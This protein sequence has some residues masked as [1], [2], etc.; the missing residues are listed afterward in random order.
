MKFHDRGKQLCNG[1]C[2]IIRFLELFGSARADM[3]RK[4]ASVRI[5][6][7]I[8]NNYMAIY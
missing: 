8:I 2:Y 4:R 5:P 7:S 6:F 3:K 1:L